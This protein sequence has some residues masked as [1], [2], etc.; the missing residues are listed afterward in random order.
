MVASSQLSPGIMISLDGVIYRVESSVRVSAPKGQPFIKTKLRDV[1]TDKCVE[2]NFKPTQTVQEVNLEERT[3]EYLYVEEDGH[4]FLDIGNLEQVRV[5]NELVKQQ[6]LYLKEGVEVKAFFYGD[7]V[8][9]VELPQFLELMVVG[10][11]GSQSKNGTAASVSATLETGARLEVPAYIETGDMIKV[12][13]FA[14]E[15]VQRV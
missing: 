12:D 5:S 11:D 14:N 8:F 3:L 9:S 4:L 10:I 15:Y 7:V 13:T 2:K 1:T 6:S